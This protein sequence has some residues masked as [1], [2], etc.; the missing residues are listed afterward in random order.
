MNRQPVN[1][2]HFRQRHDRLERGVHDLTG[3]ERVLEDAI[4]FGE[5]FGDVAAAEVRIERDVGAGPAGQVLEIRKH[6]CRPQLVM[7]DRRVGTRGG[8]LVEHGIERL[9]LNLDQVRRFF[10]EMGIG[11][12]RHRDRL[13]HVPNLPMRQNRLVVECRSVVGVGHQREHV[14]NRDDGVNPGKRQRG[15][16]IDP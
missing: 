3:P 10:G 1:A 16:R 8:D 14:L 6:P 11:G 12:E 5:P 15:A 7:N 9:V 4:G 13:A 2:R